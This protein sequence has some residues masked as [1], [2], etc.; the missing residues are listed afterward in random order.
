MRW[1]EID[2]EKAVWTLPGERVKNGR[3]HS[4][5]LSPRAIAILASL[6]RVAGETDFVFTTNGRTAVSG[7]SKTIS[8]LRAA[9]PDAPP[10]VLHDLRRSCATGMARLGVDLHVIERCLN[11]VSGSFSG[12]VGV[13]QKFKFEDGM[14]RAMDAWAAHIER[15]VSGDVASNVVELVKARG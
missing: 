10:F 11:H 15:L 9:L 13:Y 4:V 5:P 3:T 7:F 14:R 8:R 2:L 12:I 6:P 1:R